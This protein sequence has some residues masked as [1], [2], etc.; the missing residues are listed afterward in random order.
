MDNETFANLCAVAAFVIPPLALL[1]III[2]PELYMKWAKRLM[3]SS[4]KLFGMELIGEIKYTSKTRTMIR[5]VGIFILLI[6]IVIWFSVGR[7][8]LA[9]L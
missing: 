9:E 6:L 1:I 3:K 8:M 7:K 2:K 4:L 5:L